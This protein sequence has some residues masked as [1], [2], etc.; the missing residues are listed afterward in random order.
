MSKELKMNLWWSFF[1]T[2]FAVIY[3]VIYN[4]LPLKNPAMWCTYVTLPIFFAWRRREAYSQI[5]R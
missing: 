3:A 5:K 2:V 4:M 1:I